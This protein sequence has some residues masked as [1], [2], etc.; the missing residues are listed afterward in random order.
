MH[1]PGYY[2]MVLMDDYVRAGPTLTIHSMLY[3]W[4][5]ENGKEIKLAHFWTEHKCLQMML[6]NIINCCVAWDEGMFYCK[7]KNQEEQHMR[8][9][10]QNADGCH[11]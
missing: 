11:Y 5:G 9:M 1:M 2:A 3:K 8:I 4:S 10:H 6:A 7:T